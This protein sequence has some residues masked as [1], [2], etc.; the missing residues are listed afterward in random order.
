MIGRSQE[1]PKKERHVEFAQ[2]KQQRTNNK[3]QQR[4]KQQTALHTTDDK[5][6][7]KR[8]PDNSFRNFQHAESGFRLVSRGSQKRPPKHT[9]FRPLI[10]Q[11]LLHVVGDLW[12]AG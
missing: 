7:D 1:Q 12:C 3:E 9:F 2:R 4:T 11:L 6:T 5:R 8:T 10:F